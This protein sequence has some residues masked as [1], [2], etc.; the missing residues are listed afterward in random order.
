MRRTWSQ[1]ET[2]ELLDLLARGLEAHNRLI[3]L[4]Q[5]VGAL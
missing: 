1:D 3:S 2:N 4:Q 5:Q